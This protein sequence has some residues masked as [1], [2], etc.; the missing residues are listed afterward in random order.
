MS[1]HMLCPSLFVY[2]SLLAPAVKSSFLLPASTGR[3]EVR[4]ATPH[5]HQRDLLP[6][7]RRTQQ[8][9][10][11]SLNAA[12]IQTKRPVVLFYVYSPVVI[13]LS[14]ECCPETPPEPRWPPMSQK[15]RPSHVTKP[16]CPGWSLTFGKQEEEEINKAES[17]LTQPLN[18]E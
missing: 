17:D 9:R 5:E 1:W 3:S 4:V 10:L 8:F 15:Q 7:L 11:G 12:V 2:Y 6:F 18:Q 14:H 16:C 13:S